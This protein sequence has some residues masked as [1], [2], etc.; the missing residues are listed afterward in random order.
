MHM[1]KDPHLLACMH[2]QIRAHTSTHMRM[3]ARALK[4]VLAG[5]STAPPHQTA[6]CVCGT[7]TPT[8]RWAPE[9]CLSHHTPCTHLY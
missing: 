6:R 1:H 5:P 3:R 8:S 9:G 2:T 7:W 4:H